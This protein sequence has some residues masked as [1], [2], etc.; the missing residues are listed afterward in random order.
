MARAVAAAGALLAILTGAGAAGAQ[1]TPSRCR[2]QVVSVGGSGRIVEG[3]AGGG[4]AYFA[5]GGVK[6]RCLGQNV[7]MESDSV[8]AYTNGDVDFIGRMR[9]RDSTL[10]LDAARG[11]YRKVGEV[12]EARGDVL[13]RNLETGSTIRGPSIDFL[14]AASGLR[15]SSEVFATGRPTVEYFEEDSATARPEPYRIVSD[16]LRSRGKSLIWA[17]GQVRIDRSDLAARGDSM[18]LDTGAGDDG[19]LIGRAVFNGLGADSFALSGSRIDFSLDR[20]QLDDV[21]ASERAHLVR[22]DWDLVADTI[23]LDLESRKVVGMLAWGHGMRP[24]ARSDRH[25]VRADSVAFDLP[26]EM[27]R[28]VRAFGGAWVAGAV[29]SASGERDWLA[30]DTVIADFVRREPADSGRGKSALTRLHGRHDARSFHTEAP[31]TPGGRPSLAYVK[32]AAITIVMQSGAGEEVERV[33]VQ[34]Q[35][36]GINLQPDSTAS[37]AGSRLPGTPPPTAKPAPPAAPA[38]GAPK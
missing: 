6:L 15:D 31:R 11:T 16:R 30:G 23:S 7:T 24:N 4:A 2:V 17:A 32:G 26:D 8:A 13:A 18:R 1:E 12:W 10:A 19:T 34:G 20:R 33:D 28:Q 3:G 36:E 5:G 25:A 35:V 9:Y 27:L 22:G 37:A 14:R 38:G 29:D 21:L